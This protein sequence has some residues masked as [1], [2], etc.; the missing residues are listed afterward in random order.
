MS[1]RNR[2]KA[3]GG[4]GGARMKE[5]IEKLINEYAMAMD[6]KRDQETTR[7]TGI[8]KQGMQISDK[9]ER[10]RQGVKVLN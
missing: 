1:T 3:G 9:T 10:R 7:R 5:Q 2:V 4:G 6:V 8:A